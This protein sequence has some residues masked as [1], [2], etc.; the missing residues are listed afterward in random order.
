MDR[1]D[2][3]EASI[4]GKAKIIWDEVIAQPFGEWWDTKGQDYFMKKFES[5]GKSLGQGLST[6]FK[7]LF[8]I[9]DVDVNGDA[10]GLGGSFAK[11]FIDGFDANGVAD[12]F[13]NALKTG[14]SK[15]FSGNW[16][17]NI[18]LGGLVLKGTSTILNGVSAARNLWYGSEA[19]A[20][21][22]GAGGM[23]PVA[24][25]GGI[26][27]AIGSTGNAMV[28]GSGLLGTMANAGYALT[29]GAAGSALSGGAAALLGGASIAGA[30]G[31]IAG[32]TNSL[33]DTR[34]AITAST[35]NDRKLYGTRAAVKGGMTV[36]GAGAGAAAGAAI[37][38]IFG[39]VGAIPGALIGAGIGGISTFLAGNK[40]ADSISGVSKS[41]AELKEEAQA[42]KGENMAKAFGDWQMSA[43]ELSNAVT[44]VIG[45]KN[46]SRMQKY[47]QETA[48]LAAAEQQAA[49]YFDSIS[50]TNQRIINKEELSKNDIN[51][52]ADAIINY[53]DSV[54]TLIQ[55]D[56][57]STR[58]A[59]QFLYQDDATGLTNATKGIN[60]MYNSMERELEA[61]NKQLEET[62]SKALE[63]GVISGDENKIIQKSVAKIQKIEEAINQQIQKERA[64]ET[65]AA[66]DLIEKKYSNMSIDSYKTLMKELN[67]QNEEAFAT[68]DEAY[69]KAKAKLDLQLETKAINDD[70]YKTTLAE[71]EN[72][73]L[74]ST[75]DPLKKSVN[76]SLDVLVD[77]YKTE[78]NKLEK[79]V[80]DKDISKLFST[81]QIKYDLGGTWTNKNTKMFQGIQDSFLQGMG[82]TEE[83][84]AQM[85]DYYKQLEPQKSQLEA[86]KSS[87]EELGQSVPTWITDALAN[88]EGVGLMS[89]S[90]DSF[91][92]MIGAEIARSDKEL[93][94]KLAST[95]G[96][97]E[98]LKAGIQNGLDNVAAGISTD[99]AVASTQEKI[100]AAFGAGFST[101]APTQVTPTFSSL[102]GVSPFMGNA[103]MALTNSIT[104]QT[105][106]M[107]F[108][109]KPTNSE[110]S[111][112]PKSANGRITEGP[113]LSWIGEDGP[114]AVIPL[115]AKRRGRGL[116]LWKEAG[117]RLGVMYNADGGLY[118]EGG[119]KIGRL[120]DGATTGSGNATESTQ[121]AHRGNIQVEVGGITIQLTGSGN[122]APEELMNN[123]DQIC[124]TIAIALQEAFQNLP[125][126]E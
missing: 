24:G 116:E 84:Q 56:K 78:F 103:L 87:Y 110:G 94:A 32:L 111:K 27:G 18:I 104:T 13:T 50:Y 70:Q 36:G 7:A 53:A 17:S 30:V 85:A 121:E 20:A 68:A 57:Q 34:K 25:I 41:T 100:D 118:G 31:G 49:Q 45:E 114:E 48:N 28:G 81:E 65:N 99:N 69:I 64:A 5:G 44:S 76:I 63:D 67:A 8:G 21:A 106:N 105:V 113:M 61:G 86:L 101:E 62:I 72:K 11:G 29:G 71:I 15:L 75:S 88:I 109:V 12:A 117:R 55:A 73:Y 97:P 43:N 115:G 126:A 14:L 46:I 16:L 23:I 74:Q 79:A 2:F 80:K 122:S 40:V 35:E 119:S 66:Y 102:T 92:N 120:L 51:E 89:G 95:S 1:Q 47:R 22:G 93:A 83:I 108:K 112:T 96:V 77:N 124:N 125:L 39:G 26:R 98:A 3:K 37:G 52:Y 82:A 6:M 4:F 33:N 54:K 60:K 90:M 58:A 19:L 59:F 38:A 107:P 9:V 10:V 123:K 42:L 91:Y